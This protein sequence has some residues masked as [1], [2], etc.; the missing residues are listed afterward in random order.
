MENTFI[1]QL[2]RAMLD[3]LRTEIESAWVNNRDDT[4]VD[5]L[6]TEYPEYAEAL[7]DFFSLLID[8][9]LDE[10][11][12]SEDLTKS[13]DRTR[14]WLEQEGY[15]Q[16][17]RIGREQDIEASPTSSGQTING[18]A[19]G[20]VA[21]EISENKA[22]E[23]SGPTSLLGHM[24]ERTEEKPTAIAK[25]MDIPYPFLLLVQRYPK[26][27]PKRARE[28]V[29]S[30]AERAGGDRSEAMRLLE[31]PSQTAIAASRDSPYPADA[32]TYKEMV[33]RSGMSQKDKKYWLAFASEDT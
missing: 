26:N 10:N 20:P 5:R 17:C 11:L 22:T 8:V 9:E 7:Y 33:K 19:E 27:V 21:K 23:P 14:I 13:V 15:R 18:D 2:D 24:C 28:E 32:P 1:P 30:R 12:E 31:H 6:A 16:A 3:R 4:V 25:R 29:A